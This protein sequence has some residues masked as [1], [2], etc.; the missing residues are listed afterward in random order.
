VPF[1]QIGYITGLPKT[2]MPN[3]TYRWLRMTPGVFGIL[4]AVF[5]GLNW[6][7]RRRMRRERAEGEHR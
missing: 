7:V 2:P 1:E 4:Y 3:L 5:A 6:I